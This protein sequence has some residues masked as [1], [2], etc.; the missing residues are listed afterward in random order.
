MNKITCLNMS[1]KC[2]LW[3]TNKILKLIFEKQNPGERID[4][5]RKWKRIRMVG[6]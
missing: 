5:G 2:T 6:L 3:M 1:Q 4:L